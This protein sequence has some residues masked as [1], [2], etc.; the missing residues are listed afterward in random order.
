[1]EVRRTGAG[2]HAQVLQGL[3][4]QLL[5]ERGE[6]A[7]LR[8]MLEQEGRELEAAIAAK[9]ELEAQLVQHLHQV[10]HLAFIIL[11]MLPLLAACMPKYGQGSYVSLNKLIF[12]VPRQGLG[13]LCSACLCVRMLAVNH[14]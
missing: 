9:A 2:P 10:R 14:S 5:T 12:A 11:A 3:T 1:M 4:Q 13:L 8:E 7:T 6:K